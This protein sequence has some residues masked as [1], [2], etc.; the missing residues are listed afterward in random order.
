[1]NVLHPEDRPQ[2]LKEATYAHQSGQ[3]FEME[4]RMIARDGRIVWVHDQSAPVK[5]QEVDH[6]LW[7]GFMFD[8]T[9][10][11]QAESALREDEVRYR[12]L[13]EDSPVALWEED[14]SV[15]KQRFDMLREQGV[16]DFQEYFN[17][18]PQAVLEFAALVKVLDVNKATLDLYAEN[19]K[20]ALIENLAN[21]IAGEQFSQ[22]QNELVNIAEGKTS[23][24]W[25]GIVKAQDGTLRNIEL[26]WR[27]VAGHEDTLSRVIISMTNI[28]ERK[29]GEEKLIGA[30]EFL[31]SV[32][33][34]L[35]SHIAI[36]DH[37]GNIVQVNS[38][39][40]NFGTQ[41]GLNQP[42]YCV[43]MNYLDACDSAKGPHSDEARLVANAIREVNGGR[44]NE[45]LVEYPCHDAN[46]QRWFVARITSFENNHQKWTVVSHENITERKLMENILRENEIRYRSLF[47]DSPVALWEED[48][49]VVKQRLDILREQGVTD[50][51]EYFNLHPQTVVEFGALIKVLD[52][53]NATLSLFAV[54]KKSDLMEN[55]Q[56]LIAD[57][58]FSQFQ[59][60]LVNLAKGKTNFEWEGIVKAQDGTLRNIEV[61]WQAVPG[62][63]DTL[64]RVIISMTN[65]TGRKQ[66]ERRIKRQLEHLT[67]LSAIDRVIA[68]NFDLELS[69]L[70][71]LKHVTVELGVDAADI[72]I[73][74]SNS[75]TLEYGAENGFR[76]QAIRNRQVRLG[77]SYAGRA[78]LERR[79]VE[80]SNLKDVSDNPLMMDHLAGEDFVCYYGVPLIAKGQVKGVLEIFH[81]AALDP[82]REWLDF[83]KMLAGQAALAIENATLFESLQRSNLEL[84]LAYDATIEGWSRALDLRD[85]E[86]EGHTQRVTAMTVK[87][88]RAFGLSDAELVQVRWGAL[89]HDIGKMGVPDGIL[90]KPGPLTE[91]EWVAM[92]KH[93]AF[94][95]EMLAPIRYLRLALDIPYYHHER[96]DGAGY[97]HELKGEYIPLVAR[98]FAVVDVWDALKSDRPYRA[99]WAEEKVREHIRGL[100]GTHFDPQVVDMFM[101]MSN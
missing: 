98:I 79:L 42:N 100:S 39:W 26:S 55:L 19:E 45:I 86:T 2:V 60:D 29:Q 63:E 58:T 77:E 1:M 91:E 12:S 70:E 27:A 53:N 64:S 96:W 47:E 4:Y 94:A 11:K 97:P 35:S 99:G 5:S 54:K 50:F 40:S 18:H 33:D 89:L 83:F 25:E 9:E 85:K 34:A 61:N 71:I 30:R 32:Q 44:K 95:Y 23:F 88:A 7:Q 59:N 15:V 75:Q 46:N 41:N 80:I 87:L 38:A 51:E 73:L 17:L 37:E 49:S 65:I 20:S 21:Q 81:R 72:L 67:A 10:R 36:L 90:L 57:E 101:R 52:I 74:N 13:F 22:F 8:I 93:P 82:D 31:Q 62:H 84:A 76:T 56:N 69:L 3:P 48:F 92:K 16:T 43:G 28:T 14:F 68:A 6:Q 78:A 24:G 66:A